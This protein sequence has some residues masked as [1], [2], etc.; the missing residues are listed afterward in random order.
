MRLGAIV[1]GL[2]VSLNGLANEVAPPWANPE[3]LVAF[4][5]SSDCATV[6]ARLYRKEA[7]WSRVK[8]QVASGDP[9]W[10]AAAKVLRRCTDGGMSSELHDAMFEALRA[11][12]TA[13]LSRAEPEFKLSVLCGGRADPLP[14]FQAAESE[15]ELT[16]AAVR[17]I[18]AKSLESRKSSC[19]ARLERGRANLK[20]FFK[21]GASGAF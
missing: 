4:A 15:Q 6:H 5:K 13:V 17:T 8:A 19:L 11:N 1:V 14:T 3:A 10:I 7:G 20:R 18:G 21:V 2:V 16:I 9:S 12:P